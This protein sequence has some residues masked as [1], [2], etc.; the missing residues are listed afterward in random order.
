MNKIPLFIKEGWVESIEFRNSMIIIKK[1]VVG[2][3]EKLGDRVIT[4]VDAQV[5]DLQEALAQAA[6]NQEA[7]EEGRKKSKQ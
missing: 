1:S 3:I 6:K 2:E 7:K 5:K 4:G